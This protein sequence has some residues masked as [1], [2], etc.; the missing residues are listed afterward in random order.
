MQSLLLREERSVPPEVI[1]PPAS[2]AAEGA[3]PLEELPKI[4]VSEL[5]K[6]RVRE[7][8]GERE[9]AFDATAAQDAEAAPWWQ[10]AA[11]PSTQTA[12]ACRPQGG[13]SCDGNHQPW[14]FQPSPHGFRFVTFAYLLGIVPPPPCSSDP[15]CRY[16]PGSSMFCCRRGQSSFKCIGRGVRRVVSYNLG[17]QSPQERRPA[18]CSPPPQVNL[19]GLSSP[20][21]SRQRRNSC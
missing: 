15:M 3:G 16:Y 11:R 10:P 19:P 21:Q 2:T 17:G 8:N 4:L 20:R 14:A 13:R 7:G 6:C 1:R 12:Q 18:L 9:L 5:L